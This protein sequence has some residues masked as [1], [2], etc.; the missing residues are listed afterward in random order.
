MKTL[1]RYSFISAIDWG[2]SRTIIPRVFQMASSPGPE[3]LKKGN[4]IPEEDTK[5]RGS[6]PWVSWIAIFLGVGMIF[7]GALVLLW[8]LAWQTGVGE[9]D[10]IEGSSGGPGLIPFGILCVAFGFMWV[11]TGWN[12]FKKRHREEGLRSCP[13][14]GRRIEMD[15]NFCYYCNTTFDRERDKKVAP[16]SKREEKRARP[17]NDGKR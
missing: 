16:V 4:N 17:L 12:R 6:A 2:P 10:K 15:L 1:L 14:C 7:V 8:G 13:N 11:L 5:E 3:H 9:A